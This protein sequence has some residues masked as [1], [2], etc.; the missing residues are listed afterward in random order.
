MDT[1]ILIDFLRHQG[2]NMKRV[3]VIGAMISATI[4]LDA[5]S[6]DSSTNFV[7]DI[8]CSSQA[9]TGSSA[10]KNRFVA[11]RIAQQFFVGAIV[12]QHAPTNI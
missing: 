6:N 2:E 9:I 4:G 11:V 7:E 1:N 12:Q 10:K 8:S 5:C 3:T